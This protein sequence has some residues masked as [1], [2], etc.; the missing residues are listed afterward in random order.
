M[1]YRARLRAN[2]DVADEDNEAA[3]AAAQEEEAGAMDVDTTDDTARSH[4]PNIEAKI[5]LF[6]FVRRSEA[7][8]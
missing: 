5:I 2:A 6:L 7:K 8:S 4:H 1:A 3:D